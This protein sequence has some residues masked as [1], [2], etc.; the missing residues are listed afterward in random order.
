MKKRTIRGLAILLM[1]TVVLTMM[2]LSAFAASKNPGKAKITS[3]KLGKTSRTTAMTTVTVKWKKVSKATGYEVWGKHGTDQ[4]TRIKK[5]GR[6]KGGLKIKKV[7]SGRISIKVRAIRKVKGKVYY[8]KFSKVK[9]KYI[10]SPLTLQQLGNKYPAMKNTG[11]PST[12]MTFSGNTA[13]VTM[14]LLRLEPKLAAYS[15]A[16]VKSIAG[17]LYNELGSPKMFNAAATVRTNVSNNTG[18]SNARV[19]IVFVFKGQY[20]TA[21]DY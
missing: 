13:I 15:V 5:V 18:V 11:D 21:R 3:F 12:T 16:D 10:K 19:R 1:V 17:E 2:P 14:D 7:P 20:I 6:L 4:W 9:S 8:G